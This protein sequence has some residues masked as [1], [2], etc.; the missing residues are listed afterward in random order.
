MTL[1][2]CWYILQSRLITTR[3]RCPLSGVDFFSAFVSIPCSRWIFPSAHISQGAL[4]S[5]IFISL[6][7]TSVRRSLVVELGFELPSPMRRPI[8]S[9][10]SGAPAPAPAH[11]LRSVA[12][13][14]LLPAC[15]APSPMALLS[16]RF[17]ASA[18]SSP[19][20]MAAPSVRPPAPLL[21]LRPVGSPWSSPSPAVLL[22][23]SAR[24][25]RCSLGLAVVSP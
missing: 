1:A 10:L 7:S 6:S 13:R 2:S 25:A 20:P 8:S 3:R 4:C 19:S 24:R 12:A 22:S 18:R 11:A 15:P 14:A 17:Q 23:L 21:G 16:A 5:L 9:L